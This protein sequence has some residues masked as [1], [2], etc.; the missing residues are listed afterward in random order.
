M[1]ILLFLFFVGQSTFSLRAQK[2]LNTGFEMGTHPP[3]PSPKSWQYTRSTSN[4][5]E[6]HEVIAGYA[7]D[8]DKKVR[9]SG[10]SSLKM[11]V[12]DSNSF[13]VACTQS[14]PITIATPATIHISIWIKTRD[15]PLGAGL[16]CTQKNIE[17]KQIAYTSSRQQDVLVKNTQDWTKREITVL[18][19]PDTKSLDLW[20]SFY[21][22]GT[23]WFDDV[24]ITKAL[25]ADKTSPLVSAYVDTVVKMVKAYSLYKDSI[26]WKTF[27]PQLKTLSMGMQ[28]YAHARLLTSY[29]VNELH[30][31]GDNHSFLMNPAAVKQFGQADIQGRGRVVEGEYL[32]EG[33]GYIAMPGFASMN[34]SIRDAFATNTQVVIRKLDAENSICGWIVDMRG[35]DGGSCPPMIAGLGPILGEGLCGRD[36]SI[37]KDSVFSY[38]KDGAYYEVEKGIVVKESVCRSLQP[39]KL[40]NG[41]VPVAVLIGKGC[42]S[43]GEATVA[44]FIGREK[45][46]LFGEPTAGF[47]KGN[48]DFVLPDSSMLFLSAGIQTDRNGKSYPDRIYP[49]VPVEQ[50][51]DSDKDAVLEKAKE[52]LKSVEGCR[53]K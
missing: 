47:T 32:G 31:H 12:A 27:S 41:N 35:D 53:N 39:Y 50:P 1:R 16:N 38:Y 14:I 4:G 18:L 19:R 5:K 25:P 15:C 9:H 28:T 22:K 6:N 33:I 30:I 49:D 11:S 26:N 43:S 42:G 37:K 21:G 46:K 45:T 23:V 8:L 51:K 29:I 24:S 13:I 52:W 10:Q 2:V 17:G 40:R 7:I 20:A 48:E 34:D 36:I 44:V 3:N